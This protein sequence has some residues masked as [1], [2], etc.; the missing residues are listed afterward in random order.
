VGQ[1][2][3]GGLRGRGLVGPNRFDR[4][5]STVLTFYGANVFPPEAMY[6]ER[7]KLLTLPFSEYEQSLREDLNRILSVAPG[8]FD[9]DRD[10]SAVY[11]Y[12][13]GHGMVFP[14]LGVP[15]GVPQ[16]RNGQT[17]RTPAGRHVARAAVGRISFGGQDT[18]SSPAIESAIGSGLRTALEALAWL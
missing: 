7:V 3:L 2:V 5:R 11:I 13:W 16:L 17:I 6:D 18:E 14:K 4:D 15:F 1:Q 10:V 12:R 8:G 9:F